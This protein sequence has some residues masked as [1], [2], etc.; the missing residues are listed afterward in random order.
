MPGHGIL[1]RSS[2]PTPSPRA[3]CAPRL[4]CACCAATGRARSSTPTG[5]TATRRRCS[6]ATSP[7]SSAGE[8]GMAVVGVRDSHHFGM[9]GRTPSGSRRTGLVG[10]VLTNAQPIM[11]PPGSR[12]RSSAT[13]PRHRGAA[14]RAASAARPRHGDEP[15]RA[16]PHPPGR[17]GGR[18]IPEGWALDEQGRRRRT[19]RGAGRGA[20]RAD[21]RP[22]GTALVLMIDVLAGVMT[23]SPAGTGRRRPRSPRGRRG[24]SRHRAAADALRRR[25]GLRRGHR[26][27]PRGS[28]R[29][30]HPRGPVV[31]PG[32]P[33]LEARERAGRDGVQI[34]SELAEQLDALAMRL[35]VLPLS[36]ARG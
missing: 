24:P 23:G 1:R 30:G 15:D 22:Q 34:S 8:H 32:D 9:A 13:T 7:P 25:R 14:G 29:P 16:R 21:R 5:A 11:A 6:R 33:E 18:P 36:V 31:F 26:A 10:I 20:A 35:G 2:T 3:T 19:P 27:A 12:R 17:R 4:T 28:A